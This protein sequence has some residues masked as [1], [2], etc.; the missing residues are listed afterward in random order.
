MQK[1]GSWRGI[2]ALWPVL[3]ASMCA[4]AT[5]AGPARLHVHN[6]GDHDRT[7]A[8]WS[9]QC[10]KCSRRPNGRPICSNI[11]IACVPHKVKCMKRQEREEP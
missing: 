7:C 10:R 9:D 3:F 11:G 8:I 2:G 1:L 4:T 6:Y 5:L